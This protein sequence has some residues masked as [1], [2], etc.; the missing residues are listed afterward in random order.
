MATAESRTFKADVSNYGWRF[1]GQHEVPLGY[2]KAVEKG[3]REPLGGKRV[4]KT[5]KN[6]L[7]RP[8]SSGTISG[9]EK[10]SQVR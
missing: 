4:R 5:M 8:S 10:R 7:K 2:T 1:K 9:Q 3:R 6:R